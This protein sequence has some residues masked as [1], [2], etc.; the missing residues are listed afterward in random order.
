MSLHV[1][2]YAGL[3]RA[4]LRIGDGLPEGRL[5]TRIRQSG[6]ADRVAKTQ[7]TRRLR[8]RRVHRPSSGRAFSGRKATARTPMWMQ[9]QEFPFFFLHGSHR[10]GP[11]PLRQVNSI[12]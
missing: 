11:V 12:S 3:Q 7:S 9:K 1:A 5:S 6:A 2:G 8:L 10:G 4:G